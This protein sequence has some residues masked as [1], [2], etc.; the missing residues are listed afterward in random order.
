[1]MKM[2]PAWWLVV[3]L[4]CFL[5]ACST[6]GD[7]GA[8]P[9]SVW[10]WLTGR[11]SATPTGTGQTGSPFAMFAAVSGLCLLVGI[12]LIFLQMRAQGAALILISVGL[13]ILKFVLDKYLGLILVIALLTLLVLLGTSGGMMW[14]RLQ[15]KKGYQKLFSEGKDAEAGALLRIWQPD[16]DKAARKKAKA[17]RKAELEA[18]QPGSSGPSLPSPSSPSS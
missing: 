8:T 16:Q 14:V 17:K 9:F 5:V 3:F 2:K 18:L 1:M 7:G 12:V 4:F 11:T 10:G 6:G 15:A 13:S